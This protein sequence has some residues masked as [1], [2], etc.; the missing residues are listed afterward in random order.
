MPAANDKARLRWQ[1][2]LVRIFA[3]LL[4]LPG[5]NRRRHSAPERERQALPLRRR[6]DQGRGAPNSGYSP[7]IGAP[8]TGFWAP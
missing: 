2:G 1:P 4:Q 5:Q 7:S 8:L 3:L 6:I